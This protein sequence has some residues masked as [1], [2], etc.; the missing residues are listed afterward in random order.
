MYC[1]QAPLCIVQPGNFTDWGSEGVNAHKHISIVAIFV[2][3]PVDIFSTV[4]R[5][6]FKVYRGSFMAHRKLMN[7]RVRVYNN[8][9]VHLLTP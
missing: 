2:I 1:L 8:N 6:S 3:L 5:A 4:K 9:N 7:E